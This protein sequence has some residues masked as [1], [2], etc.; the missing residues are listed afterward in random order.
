MFNIRTMKFLQLG[1]VYR[2]KCI[3]VA[4]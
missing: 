3:T 4:K 2:P 1:K